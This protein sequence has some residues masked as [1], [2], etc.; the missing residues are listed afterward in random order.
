MEN[1]RPL[2]FPSNSSQFKN[3]SKWSF[4][5]STLRLQTFTTKLFGILKH[6][7]VRSHF[8][9][10]SILL[11]PLLFLLINIHRIKVLKDL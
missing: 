1:K 5:S 4:G 9:G 3:I 11:I 2:V 8:W 10:F 7:D 6:F